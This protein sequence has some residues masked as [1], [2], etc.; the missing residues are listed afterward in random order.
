MRCFLLKRFHLFLKSLEKQ[1]NHFYVSIF[2]LGHNLI[3]FYLN[4]FKEYC[5]M[6]LDNLSQHDNII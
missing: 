6:Q 4:Y 1:E 5:H 2:C 3:A